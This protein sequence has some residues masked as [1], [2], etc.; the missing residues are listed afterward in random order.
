MDDDIADMDED[1]ELA[2]QEQPAA[3]TDNIFEQEE[4]KEVPAA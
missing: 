3:D 1:M 4:Y 2:A